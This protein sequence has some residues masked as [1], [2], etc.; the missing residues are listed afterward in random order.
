MGRDI[1]TALDVFNFEPV[2]PEN[3]DAEFR[4]APRVLSSD[5]H[6]NCL[7]ELI[8]ADKTACF[9]IKRSSV[10]GSFKRKEGA[11]FY[12]VVIDGSG[13]FQVGD[14]VT[15]LKRWERFFCPA[16]VEEFQ[17]QSDSGMTILECYPGNS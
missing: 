1:E 12:G 3:V 9:T 17:Y 14:E 4:C 2:P 7:E 10:K 16:G 6:G 11:F 8:G 15:Q 5:E 13:T